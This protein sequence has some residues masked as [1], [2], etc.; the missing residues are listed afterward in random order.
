MDAPK[1]FPRGTAGTLIVFVGMSVILSV[2]PVPDFLK[3]LGFLDGEAPLSSF[4]TQLVTPPRSVPRP[5]QGYVAGG[6]ALNVATEDTFA[7][8]DEEDEGLASR[9]VTVEAGPRPQ[10][11]RPERPK[12]E[13]WAP[14]LG[15]EA[16][17]L[18]QV[19]AEPGADGCTR[20]SLDRFF[21]RLREAERGEGGPVRITH[22][23]DSLIASD[24]ITDTVRLRLQ[25]RFG[26][27]G[28][29]FLMVRKFNRFQRGNRTGDGSGGWVLDVITQG[30][31]HDRYFG[32]TG[33]SFTAQRA[34][35]RSVFSPVAGSTRA[36]VHFLEEPSGGDL[37]LTADGEPLGLV[38]TRATRPRSVARFAEFA[39]PEGAEQVEM[40]AE[41]HGP[42]V[43][44]VV[45]E[46]EVPGIVYESIG[47]P[48]ATSEV[49][50]RPDEAGFTKLLARR[51]PELVVH[52]VGGNDGLM[53]SKNRMTE[54]KIVESMHGFFERVEA[55][56]PQA[57]CLV[58]T[59]MEAV[60]ARAD[61][62]MD[63]KPEVGVIMRLQRE[64]AEARGCA[65]WD[66]YASMGGEG[67]LRRWVDANLMLGDLIHPRSRGSDLIGEMM[68]EALMEAYDAAE[69]GRR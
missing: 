26:S 61:G 45:L 59:P 47:L 66:M 69:L 54:E 18:E 24:K 62:S 50:L 4:W 27:A 8:D 37:R 67:S 11:V 63:P 28:R 46:A 53:L 40:E 20:R 49:W 51:A 58:V 36:E 34:G 15:L 56:V 3:P 38:D 39:L 60:R 30:V 43:F 29:G 19:C 1:S 12:F 52:M 21:H 42:R 16:A 31:L 9:P 35:E 65:V 22:F 23:G 6:G 41:T 32:Y 5:S 68:A 2:V 57:D 55:A 7:E 64:V 17:A 44:G 14:K 33:A 48:G 13:A 10:W 25:E